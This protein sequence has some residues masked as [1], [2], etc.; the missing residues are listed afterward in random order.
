MT[1]RGM[2]CTES[3]S[4]LNPRFVKDGNIA[5]LAKNRRSN[6]WLLTAFEQGRQVNRGE[7]SIYFGLRTPRLRLRV[8]TSSSG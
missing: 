5:V 7:F 3:G 1:N 4:S 8:T 2:A 6:C